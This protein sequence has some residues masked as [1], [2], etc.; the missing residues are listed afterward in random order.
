MKGRSTF[1]AE[2]A[3]SVRILSSTPP[4]TKVKSPPL[5]G[6]YTVWSWKFKEKSSGLAADS[7]LKAVIFSIYSSFASTKPAGVFVMVP[8][9][10]T[11]SPHASELPAISEESELKTARRRVAGWQRESL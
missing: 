9:W 5:Q 3:L 2:Q 11:F 1:P 10:A 6:N 7:H 8:C 4:S